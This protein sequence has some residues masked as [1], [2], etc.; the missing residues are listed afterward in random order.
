M[1]C[2]TGYDAYLLITLDFRVIETTS[3][4]TLSVKDSVL[5]ILVEGVLSGVTDSVFRS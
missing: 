1:G 2:E 3:D 4:Q 5:G